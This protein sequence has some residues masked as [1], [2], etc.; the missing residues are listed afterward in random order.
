M[1][2]YGGVKIGDNQDRALEAFGEPDDVC[3]VGMDDD[4]MVVAWNYRTEGIKLTM[5]RVS[6]QVLIDGEMQDMSVYAVHKIEAL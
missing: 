5:A 6:G 2:E 1:D 4:G 3:I